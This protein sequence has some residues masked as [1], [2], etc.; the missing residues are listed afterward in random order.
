MKRLP[1]GIKPAAAIFQ[2]PMENLLCNIPFVVV[3]QDDITISGK[4]MS[5]H[6][7][8]LKAVLSRLMKASFKLNLSKCKFFPK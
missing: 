2:K 7:I 4:N 5:E 6:I 3:Y 8:N 1:F